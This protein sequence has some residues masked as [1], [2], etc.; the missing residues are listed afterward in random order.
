MPKRKTAIDI[1]SLGAIDREAG[2]VGQQLARLLREAIARG[3]LKAGERLPSTRSLASGLGLARGTVMEVFD[4]LAAEGYLD[5]RV[6]A[7][8]RVAPVLADRVPLTRTERVPDAQPA[9]AHVSPGAARYAAIGRA[10]TPLPPVPFAIGVQAGP[11]APDDNWRRL[12]KRVRASEEAAPS[13][14]AD[15]RGLPALREAIADYVRKARAVVCEPEQI[16]VTAGTQQGLYLAARVLLAP[17][18]AVWAENPAYPGLTAVLDDTNVRVQRVPVDAQG[19]DVDAAIAGDPAARAAFVTPSHQYPLGMPL[20]MSRRLAL[21]A[22]AR[23][24]DAWIVE[25]DYDS[26]LRYAGHPYPSMQGLDPARVIYLGTFSKVLF[27][28][29]RLGYAIVP[30]SLADAFTGA[31]AIMDRHAP[32]ADQHVVAAFMREGYF[33]MHIRRIRGVYAERRAALI[34]AIERTLGPLATLQPCDQGMHLLLWLA[35]GTDDVKVAAQALAAGV[36][37]RP[38]SPMYGGTS[39]RPGLVLGFG[40]FA[41]EQLEAGV[42]ALRGV[43]ERAC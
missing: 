5:A 38:I 36:S 16:I 10:L 8:T 29:L 3:D 15:P 12:G 28:S 7:G 14:Y 17:G 20:G 30:A 22:W 34:D 32:T 27:P 9:T 18:D 6:G 1:P 37:V 2:R 33:D 19:I 31:R 43:L 25:D 41:V 39:A 11:T 40:G 42:V 23:E 35:P 13:G 26:E 24:R 21:L 4:Q